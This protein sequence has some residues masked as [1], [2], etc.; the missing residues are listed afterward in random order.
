MKRHKQ[1]WDAFISFDNFSRAAR[2]MLKGKRMSR[3]GARFDA[4]WEDEVI[5]LIRDCEA[6]EYRPGAYHYFEIYEP[7]QRTVA[8]APMR[9]RVLH[10]A[11]VQIL[12]PLFEPRFIEDSFACR[13]GKGTHAGL[14]RASE[15]TQKYPW[16]LKCDIQQYFPSIDH[17]VLKLKLRRVVGD[18][19]LLSLIDRV[20][21]SHSHHLRPC[22]NAGD[23]LFDVRQ[24][25][26]GIPIGNLTSQFF[27]N[28][29]L[30]GFDHVVKQDLRVK[31]YLRYV[32][33]F[34]LFGTS[35]EEIRAYGEAVREILKPL[36]LRIHPDKYRVCR[37]SVGVDFCGFALRDDGRIR[38]RNQSA[39]RFQRRYREMK[40][41][42]K[43]GQ[44]P[45]EKVTESVQA[46]VAH[47]SHAQSWGLR[48]AI[49]SA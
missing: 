29:Y 39:R 47:A 26:V 23:E 16:V 18:R 19:R 41:R 42:N 11:L 10:H 6:G 13:K 24:V 4:V 20:I 44:I 27:A 5:R 45:V 22:W 7:K 46:W 35:R 33:D 21:D 1:L 37:T 28:V 9:D 38:V 34:L 8:A 25:G 17:E 3:Q 48:K 32:D 12:E 49:L 36:H 15:F 14:R 2:C 43:C 31:G 30:D 40:W